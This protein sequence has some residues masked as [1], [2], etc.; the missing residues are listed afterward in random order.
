[1]SDNPAPVQKPRSFF[2]KLSEKLFHEHPETKEEFI[3]K[4]QDAHGK[5]ILTDDA[6]H[7]I[8][9]V[10]EVADLRADDLMVPR[11]EM[12]VIDISDDPMNWIKQ[13]IAACPSRF[14]VVDG[15]RDNVVGIVGASVG[16]TV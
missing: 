14:H 12:Q 7:M 3:E 2:E 6:F 8:E 4:L 1:M 13:V 11:T 15:D 10:L 16:L 9:G 5:K